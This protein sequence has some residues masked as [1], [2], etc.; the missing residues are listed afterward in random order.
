MYSAIVLPKLFH[1]LQIG[2]ELIDKVHGVL[3]CYHGCRGSHS[4]GTELEMIKKTIKEFN[5]K[6]SHIKL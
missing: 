5:F 1:A 3:E 4:N 6:K 2:A